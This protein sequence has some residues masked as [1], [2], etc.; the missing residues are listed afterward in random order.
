[1]KRFMKLCA[2]VAMTLLPVRA[3]A[4]S[5]AAGN[6]ILPAAEVATFADRV[7]NDLA[8]RGARVAIVSRMGRDP[9][10]MPDGILY[11]HVAF[12]VY[13]QITLAD[14]SRGQGYRVYNLY[15]REGDRMVSDLVQDSPAEF[16]AG[17][18]RLDTG[19]IIPEPA[20]QRKLLAVINSPTYAALHNP[21]Y[22][23]LANPLTPQFQNCTEHT[24]DVL[25]AAIYDTRDSAQIRAN[26]S[27]YFHPQIVE[28]G[29]LK[30]ALATMA[31]E[32]LTTADHG[33]VVATATFGSLSRFMQSYQLTSDVYRI[34]PTTI[35]RF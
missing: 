20:L 17:A 28:V 16:F 11:T 32:A 8:S 12:W 27:A 10:Q 1:M 3:M 22:S 26:I 29:G 30:R 5:S 21:R 14:G 23:V 24:L 18:Q 9:A 7:Q 33:P 35:S 19:I 34:T 13:S 6:P 2:A 15:Q 31:S 4:G 25:M